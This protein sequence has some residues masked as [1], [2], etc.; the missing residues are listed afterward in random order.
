MSKSNAEEKLQAKAGLLKA[1]GHPVR[2]LILNLIRA[3]PRHGEELATILRLNPAT[4]SHHLAKLAE[5]GLVRSRKT[6]YYQ[7]YSLVGNLLDRTLGE[8][9]L[10]PL[11]KLSARVEEDAYR[12]KVMRA[13]FRSGRLVRIPAQLKKRHL[14]ALGAGIRAGSRLSRARGQPDPGGVPRR[15]C[16]FATR[17]DR[18]SPHGAQAR[19]IPQATRQAGS[20]GPVLAVIRP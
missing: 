5:A 6:Q 7:T 4:V 18:A 14:P 19:N 11:P 9:V 15:R 13:F 1:L 8:I 2:L 16:H 3:K 10:L 12:D 17:P 20:V